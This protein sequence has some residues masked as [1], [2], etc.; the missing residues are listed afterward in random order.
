MPRLGTDE[1]Q[2]T[3][4]ARGRQVGTRRICGAFR[5]R[6]GEA[7]RC[8]RC[9]RAPE[10]RISLARSRSSSTRRNPRS[11]GVEKPASATRLFS[12]ISSCSPRLVPDAHDTPSARVAAAHSRSRVDGTSTGSPLSRPPPLAKRAARC[13]SPRSPAARTRDRGIFF[14]CTFFY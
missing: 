14:I 9:A 6:R 12:G 13:H 10:I 5:L 4:A 11:D 2:T 1:L 7:S 3:E 8:A